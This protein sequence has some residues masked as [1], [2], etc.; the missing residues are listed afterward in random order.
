MLKK[1]NNSYY[2]SIVI[3]ISIFLFGSFISLQRGSNLSDGDSY[4]LL[5][6]FLNFLDF[7]TY[8][9]SRGAYGHL[10]PEMVLGSVAYLFGV[11][12]SNLICFIFFFS[13]IFIFFITFINQNIEKCALF[14]Y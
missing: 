4:S 14:F 5:L 1:L 10:I 3:I 12:I 6:S 2:L 13:A 9:P 11:P 8:S 7:G